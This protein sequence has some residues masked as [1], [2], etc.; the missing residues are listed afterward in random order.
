MDEVEDR[1]DLFV[2]IS[3]RIFRR[4]LYTLDV[5]KFIHLFKAFLRFENR[6]RKQRTIKDYRDLF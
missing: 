4:I 5:F 6:F 3:I 2:R 1:G